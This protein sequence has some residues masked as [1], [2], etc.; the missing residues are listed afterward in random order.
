MMETV[1]KISLVVI[2]VAIGWLANGYYYQYQG[3]PQGNFS[4]FLID[5]R[6]PQGVNS[7]TPAMQPSTVFNGRRQSPTTLHLSTMDSTSRREEKL[8]SDFT[9]SYSDY[10]IL[11]LRDIL[12]LGDNKKI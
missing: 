9:S 4:Q 11:L 2:G 7:T 12:K 10:F 3:N 1:R 5:L 6:R 8:L